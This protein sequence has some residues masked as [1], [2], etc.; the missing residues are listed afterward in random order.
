MTINDLKKITDTLFKEKKMESDVIKKNTNL[1]VDNK[2]SW[3]TPKLTVKDINE[4]YFTP[5]GGTDGA[6]TS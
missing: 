1:V 5:G 6:L 4:T 3:E 2:E